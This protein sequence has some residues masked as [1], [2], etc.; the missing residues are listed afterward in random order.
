MSAY[1]DHEASKL[2]RKFCSEFSIEISLVAEN[3]KLLLAGIAF[4]YIHGLAAHGIHYLHRP[5]PLLRDTG[6]FLLPELGQDKAYVSE[7]LFAFIFCSFAL[8]NCLI[9]VAGLASYFLSSVSWLPDARIVVFQSCIFMKQLDRVGLFI[10]SFFRTKDL[11]S[12]HLVQ[13]SCLFSG[14]PCSTKEQK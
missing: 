3:W 1:V 8:A 9:N 14:M 12:S 10:P 11:Y 5:G 4:Q 13:G 7:T 2:C 6:F